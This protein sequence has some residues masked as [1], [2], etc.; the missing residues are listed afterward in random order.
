MALISFVMSSCPSY[1]IKP[2]PDEIGV[3]Y[4]PVVHQRLEFRVK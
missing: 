2:I 4:V 1:L 3:R